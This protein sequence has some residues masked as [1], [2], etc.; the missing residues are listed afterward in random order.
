MGGRRVTEW[1][2]DEF[3]VNPA[4]VRNSFSVDQKT[5]PLGTK[6]DIEPSSKQNKREVTY[7]G[8]SEGEREHTLKIEAIRLLAQKAND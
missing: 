6:I 1:S 4:K 5:L 8:G 2:I 3:T 7:V